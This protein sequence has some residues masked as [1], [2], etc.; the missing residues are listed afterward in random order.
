MGLDWQWHG[1]ATIST[2]TDGRRG[3]SLGVVPEHPGADQHRQTS[4]L[5]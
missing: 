2:S 4:F 3:V 5:R 1:L